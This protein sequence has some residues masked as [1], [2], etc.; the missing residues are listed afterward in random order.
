VLRSENFAFNPVTG[1][2]TAGSWTSKPA[3][4]GLNNHT[5]NSNLNITSIAFSDR[6]SGFI[7]GDYNGT[8]V[9]YAR[10]LNDESNY[11]STRFWY[12]RLGRIVVSQNSRQYVEPNGKRYSYTTYDALGRVEEAGEKVE[13]VS[14]FGFASVFGTTVNNYFN[15]KVIDD[16]NLST[17]INDASGQRTE[18]THTYYDVPNATIASA[19]PNNF[20]QENLRKRVSCVVYEE[21]WDNNDATYSHATHYT[22]DIHGNV[23]TLLQDNPNTGVAGQ[24]FKRLDYEYDLISG[25]VNEVVYQEG[26][27]DLMI[28]R[29][30]Y[31]ADNRIVNVETSTDGVFYDDDAKYFYYAHGP[32][33]RTE[34]GENQVQGL[35]YVYTLQGWIKGVNSN[36]L[37]TTRDIGQDGNRV[38][39]NPNAYFAKD[40]F[41]YTLNYFAGDYTAINGT[42]SQT[43]NNFESDKTNSDLLANREDFFNG[44]ISAMVTTITNPTTGEV[45]PQGMAY[46]Y[47]Q[48]NRL[49]SAKAFVNLD[50]QTNTWQSGSMYTNRYFNEFTYDANGNI[51][52]QVR[53]A[54]NG[55]QI[56]NLTYQYNRNTNG[57]MVQNR[58]YHVN[59]TVAANTFS[60]DIDDQG[61]FSLTN[62]N[63]TNNYGYDGEG[64]LVRDDAE[65]IASITWTVTG[66]VKEVIRTSGSTKKNLKF[67]Y[68]AMGQRVAKEVYD[69]QNNWEKTIFYVRDPQGNVMAI[70]DKTINAQSQ[71]ISYK[72][73]ERDMYGSSMVGLVKSEI[74]L[75]NASIPST[76]S[77]VHGVGKK[78]YYMQNHLSNVLSVVSDLKV[79]KDWNADLVVDYCR[80]EIVSVSDVFPFGSPMQERTINS[81]VVRHSMNGQEKDDE[82]YGEGNMTTAEFWQYDTRLGRRWN[83]DP[84][85]KH[86][87]SG[88]SCFANNPI[89]SVDLIGADTAQ[90][91]TTYTVQA[92]DSPTA[93]AK[94]YNI[95]ID[96]LAAWNPS[97]FQSKGTKTYQEYWVEGQGKL[98]NIDPGDKLV[99]S[100]PNVPAPAIKPTPPSF[101]AAKDVYGDDASGNDVATMNY[102]LYSIGTGLPIILSTTRFDDI[103]LNSDVNVSGAVPIEGTD[104]KKANINTYKGTGKYSLAYGNATVYLD[105]DNKVVGFYDWI[106]YDSKPW[107]QRSTG[108][109]IITR[110][111]EAAAIKGKGYPV[112][113]GVIPDPVVQKQILNSLPKKK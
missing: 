87:Q 66:K 57:D 9:D 35:D 1:V 46:N 80:A 42:V 34:L 99:V 31:D 25:N 77:F 20:S 104:Y 94:K 47:D 85:V 13:N 54:E 68:D 71:Q 97:C 55:M 37:D 92:G 84:I 51:L 18:V 110:L 109:E 4:D 40:V 5:T 39:G 52:T 69:S 29:Y 82:I 62:V 89:N 12:D 78:Q 19:L 106:D 59:E 95:T 93:I 8:Y 76:S 36:T 61:V 72:V 38:T 105:K 58:L 113:Y 63:T 56:E 111:G 70:Y 65:E 2:Y 101:V 17:W 6:Y 44:N 73:V 43:A 79:A 49:L 112:V 45:L 102:S 10:R 74:E 24:E 103:V 50:M 30:E 91:A 15:P 23:N 11:F 83:I 98:W 41:G 108:A 48:L 86:D 14:G 26:E 53:Y 100:D 107:G 16:N 75:I 64:R 21:V 88:Y 81:T 33:A 32:L 22:Y 60:D 28:H 27:L 67:R 90:T 3:N 96:Q 7:G